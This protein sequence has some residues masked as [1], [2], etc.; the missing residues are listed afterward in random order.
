MATSGTFACCGMSNAVRRSR[1]CIT[2]VWCPR[3]RNEN[4]ACEHL[5]SH[6]TLTKRSGMPDR[7]TA[8]CERCFARYSIQQMAG[9]IRSSSRRPC[10]ASNACCGHSSTAIR[11]PSHQM[12][13]PTNIDN[14]ARRWTA[15]VSSAAVALAS[16]ESMNSILMGAHRPCRRACMGSNRR[17]HRMR[18]PHRRQQSGSASPKHNS[19]GGRATPT[20]VVPQRPTCMRPRRRPMSHQRRRRLLRRTR[21]R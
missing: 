4:F 16:L 17:H 7:Q 5:S 14:P 3:C 15:W 6:K 8:C 9:W 20:K 18:S 21:R 2:P 11:L 10:I 1:V 12:V 13:R 19:A